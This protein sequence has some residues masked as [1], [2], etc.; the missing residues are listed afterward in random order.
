[1]AERPKKP[2]TLQTKKYIVLLILGWTVL[3]FVSLFWNWQVTHENNIEKARL[4]ARSFYD[5][6]ME[7]RRWGSLH[8]GVYVPVTDTL[9][10]NPYLIVTERDITTTTGRKLTLVNPAWMT[11]QVFELIS[12]RTALPIISHLTSLKYLNPVN[13]PDTWEE[14]TLREFEQGARERDGELMISDEPYMRIMRPFK[15]EEACLKCHGHQGYK[16]GDIRGG[17]SISVP[18]RPH[19]EAEAKEQKALL[20][21]HILLWFIGAAGITLFSWNIQRHQRHILDSEEKYRILFESNPH[22]MWVYDIETYRF[23]TVNDSAVKHYGYTREEFLSMTI[24]DI[25]PS[26]DILPLM[27]NVSRVTAG[28][29][30]AGVWRHRKK[31]GSLIYVEI[32]SHTVDFGGR[33]AEIVLANDVTD[34]LKLEDQLR[35]S[36]KMEAVGLLAGGVAHDFNNVLTA[37]IGYGNLLQMKLAPTDPLRAYAENILTTSQRAAQL[38]QSLLTFSR[39]QVVNPL[40]LELNSIILRVEKLL[41]RLIRE[42]IELRTALA[43]GNTTI[44]ADSIQIEQVLMNL[45][46]NARDAMPHGGTLTISSAVVDLDAEFVDA[47]RYGKPG[48]HIRLTVADTGIGMNERTRERIFE[49]FYTTKEMGKGTGLGLATVYGIVKQH[50]GFID[51][52]SAP[53]SGTS[54]HLYFPLVSKDA[55]SPDDRSAAKLTGGTETIL[56]AE[57]D[58]IIRNL[59][60]SV[61][62]EF[63]YQVIE[64]MDGEEALRIF[65]ENRDRIDLLLLDVIM[66]RKNGKAAYEEIRRIKPGIKALFMSGY[67]ADMISKEGISEKDLS[68]ISKPVSPTELLMKVREVLDRRDSK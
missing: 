61:L 41:K 49:P 48:P 30:K 4:I 65:G 3:V 39:K 12:K 25:R 34:G 1:M 6:T 15:T 20:L 23:L 47:K 31:D 50:R 5:L 26:E 60:R 42:D 56:V 32:T 59:T 57:D 58:E 28:L 36:Q 19:F 46:T 45:V 63:G 13:Q 55:E 40:P 8:G 68:F 54:F 11:R 64:A 24:K 33:R 2:W 21:S 66:P 38:T 18:L 22:P 29:D 43:I 67:S 9:Q 7:F 53:G 62:T 37:I 52:E 27:D 16:V 35:Q 14:K 17:I 51:V 10:P 44:L